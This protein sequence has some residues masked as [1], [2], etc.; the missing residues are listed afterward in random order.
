MSV[1]EGEYWQTRSLDL[2]R[3][4]MSAYD[5][6]VAAVVGA[7]KDS[8][9]DGPPIVAEISNDARFD[10]LEAEGRK[11]FAAELEQM[12]QLRPIK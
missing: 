1:D 11:E 6:L 9:D 8:T 2:L 10:R 5:R 7:T 4:R 3:Q 12:H